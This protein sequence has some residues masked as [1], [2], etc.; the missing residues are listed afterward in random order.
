[1]AMETVGEMRA[2]NDALND[3]EELR[4]RIARKRLSILPGIVGPGTSLEFALENIGSPAGIRLVGGRDG[5]GRWNCRYVQDL[6][7]A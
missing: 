5:F 4:R 7:R 3:P 6:C 1:M 2:S